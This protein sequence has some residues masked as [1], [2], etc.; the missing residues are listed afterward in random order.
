MVL[1]IFNTMLKITLLL[2]II[3]KELNNFYL[4]YIK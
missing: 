1:F 4:I 2:G 3:K